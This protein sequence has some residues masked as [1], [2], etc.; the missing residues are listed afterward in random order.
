MQLKKQK[1]IRAALTAATCSLLGIQGADVAA[2]EG[3]WDF[4][5]AVLFYSEVDRVSAIEPVATAKRDF[6]DERFLNLKLVFDSLT[7][8]SANGATPSDQAQTFTRPSG[9]GVYTTDADETP[10][11]DT[12]KDFRVALSGQWDQPIN[13][14]Y[15]TSFGANFSAEYDYLSMSVNASLARDFNK[16][17]TTVNAGISIANDTISPDG[18]I[19]IGFSSMVIDSGQAGFDQA[20]KATREGEDDSKT[21]VDLIFGITQ[22]ISRQTLMQLSYSLSDTSGYLT[23]PFKIL[24]VVGADGRPLDYRYELRPDSRLKQSLYWQAKH[25]F[26]RDIL[27]LS[28]RLYWDDWDITS[29]TID[30][31]YRWMLNGGHFVEPHFR[32]YLQSEADF[33]QRFLRQ[34][35][36]LPEY[37]SA[38]YRLGELTGI[39][40]GLKYGMKLANE[41][42]MSLRLEYYLQ[43]GDNTDADA[44]GIL[45]ELELFPDV[46]AVIMQFSYNF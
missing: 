17:N 7:G 13:R 32:Y 39:T 1:K 8:A 4:D 24:S 3:D 25:H 35:E 29:H 40:L 22:V 6:G 27:D 20:F 41:R 23:D 42:E 37:A 5:S 28:Y 31:R 45:S 16:R 9:E 14:D 11:D 10:L 21:T 19:P 43:S 33:Y 15:K 34:G 30:V 38:D 18:D 46:E 26:N 44:P 36:S 12:F 2:E